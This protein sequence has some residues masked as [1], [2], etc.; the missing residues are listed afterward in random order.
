MIVYVNGDSHSAGAE[1]VNGHAFARDDFLYRAMGRQGHPD[2]LRASYGCCLAN[3]LGA[4]FDCDAESASSNA[5]IMRTTKEYLKD[6]KPDL[7]IIGWA[8]WEREEWLHDGE[9]WQ[10]NAGGIGFDWPEEIKQRYKP[11]VIEQLEPDV[12]NN[13]LCTWHNM[14]YRL[15]QELDELGVKHLFFNT[16]TSFANIENLKHLGADKYNWGNSYVDPYTENSS[17]YHWLK[18]NNY[19]PSYP[20]SYHFG[21]DAHRAW[22]NQLLKDYISKLT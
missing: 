15:H 16:F 1:A 19:K 11:W 22:A 21:A 9:Y 4:I 3:E 2:N 5:R 20:G 14:I 7:L 6:N 17:Y 18:L 10:V 12:I 8:T 13:K